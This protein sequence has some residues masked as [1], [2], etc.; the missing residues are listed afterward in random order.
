MYQIISLNNLG[1]FFLYQTLTHREIRSYLQSRELGK[2]IIAIGARENSSPIGL[3]LAEINQ[4]NKNAELLSIFVLPSHRQRGIGSA[5][6]DSLEQE[7]LLQDCNK[8]ELNCKVYKLTTPALKLL[9]KKFNWSELRPSV[10]ECMANDEMLK[11]P[12]LYHKYRFP[13]G[14]KIFPWAEI[15]SQERFV[16]QQSQELKPWFDEKL[17]PFQSLEIFEPL[18][19]LGL[20][21][22]DRVVGWMLTERVEPDTI[23]YKCMFVRQD[24][25]KLGLGIALFVNAIQIQD[26]AKIPKGRWYVKLDNLPM[27]RFVKKYMMPYVTS[28][29][30]ISHSYKSLV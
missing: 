11:A 23:E 7:L 27:L 4:G 14:M 18:N 1:K 30:E 24:L 22:Q 15:T 19:S 10:M 3:A 9:L 25:Q 29:E 12:W 6:L 8:I 5:L 13:S 17:N 26:K 28:F 20:R 21:Y 16:I 2:T